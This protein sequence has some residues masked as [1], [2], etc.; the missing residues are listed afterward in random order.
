MSAPIIFTIGHST[1]P[2]DDFLALLAQHDIRCLVD[3]RT[4]PYSRWNPQFNRELLATA[5]KDVGVHYVDMG[6]SLGGRPDQADLYDP[7]QERPNYS[8]QRQTPLYQ[9]GVRDLE[10]Q[11]QAERTAIMCSEGDPEICHRHNLI[12]PSLIDDGFIVQHILPDGAI[13]Q[14]EKP[15]DQ[16]G[17]FD[18]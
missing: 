8:R 3:V 13:R 14:A 2:I 16:L 15:M 17:L 18:F 6:S 5:L 1:H 11:A 4:Q 10:V 7:G 12:T 9:H